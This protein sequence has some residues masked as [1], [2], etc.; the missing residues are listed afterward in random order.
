LLGVCYALYVCLN[1]CYWFHCSSRTIPFFNHIAHIT[2]CERVNRVN[3]ELN[4]FT[5]ELAQVLHDSKINANLKVGLEFWEHNFI[6]AKTRL[7]KHFPV[8]SIFFLLLNTYDTKKDYL[9][10]KQ[11]IKAIK[12]AR[13]DAIIFP[14]VMAPFKK[15]MPST[16]LKFFAD[17]NCCPVYIEYDGQPRCNNFLLTALSR[18]TY[19]RLIM[20]DATKPLVVEY[21]VPDERQRSDQKSLSKTRFSL[22][23]PQ[24]LAH[25]VFI[26]PCND[27]EYFQKIANYYWQDLPFELNILVEKIIANKADLNAKDRSEK[28]L[29]H[30]IIELTDGNP[31][32]QQ[33]ELIKQLVS[34]GAKLDENLQRIQDQKFHDELAKLNVRAL[35]RETYSIGDAATQ[36]SKPTFK[37][38]LIFE[39]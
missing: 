17:E 13:P 3:S 14:L 37:F 35:L 4:S 39:S 36:N 1:W 12:D 29:Q 10:I 38:A 15:I 30:Y 16:N 6:D 20:G 11:Q 18:L 34:H 22:I 33:R 5:L 19:E 9:Y 31:T 23:S 7:N 2:G 32:I 24:N 28:T 21:S 25:Q 27:L 8:T 26:A